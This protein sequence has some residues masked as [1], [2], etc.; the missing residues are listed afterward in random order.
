MPAAAG[1]RFC[2]RLAAVLCSTIAA[3]AAATVSVDELIEARDLVC[4]FYNVPDWA[5]AAARF[6]LRERADMLMVI[7]NIRS[8]PGSA[9][10]VQTRSTGARPLRRYAGETGVHFV[11]DLRG[12]VV[13]TTLL[14]CEDRKRKSGREV[15]IRYSATSAWHFDSSVHR[16]PDAAFRRVAAGMHGVCEP[17]NV[18]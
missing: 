16:D 4:E 5:G 8:N 3:G 7:E 14:A 13:V 18:D 9:R 15:C 2:L 1:H 10:A 17:W 11:E 12:S 6:A